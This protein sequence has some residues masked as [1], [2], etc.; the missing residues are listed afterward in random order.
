MSRKRLRAVIFGPQGSGKG[1][2]GRLLAERF[3]VPLISAGDLF[4]AEIEENSE[5][6]KLAKV[7]VEHGCLAPDE[8]V[9]GIMSRQLKSL[10][11]RHGFILDGFPRTVEQAAHLQRILPVNNAIL[12]KISDDLA[13]ERLRYR[14]QCPKCRAVYNKTDARPA[15]P[16]RCSR[17][18]AK[19]VR[20]SDDTEETIR[21]RLMNYHFM[22]EPMA[23]LYRQKGILLMVKG[24]QAINYVHMVL[25]RK[26][27]K[28]GF[29]P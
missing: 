19:L 20:R 4:R 11:L 29:V 12:I 7:Y 23:R 26:L 5:L 17:C 24:D 6:G 8:L 15:K 27:A 14:L 9:N 10:D 21:M 3:K 25:V 13:V 2:Q 1:T 28:L 18:G 22:T 16:G